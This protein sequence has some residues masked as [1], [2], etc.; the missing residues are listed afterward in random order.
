LLDADTLRVDAP[1]PR[2][3]AALAR[4]LASGQPLSL[5]EVL[6]A[7][8][9]RFLGAHRASD[10]GPSR[11]YVYSWGLA[12]YLTFERSILGTPSFD[13]YVAPT[14][15]NDEPIARFEKLVAEPLEKFEAEWRA[16]ML[17]LRP[18]TAAAP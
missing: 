9:E 13:E 18:S 2:A 10:E 3:L 15:A 6:T 5:A 7:P 8:V 1:N 12:Y 16:A 14:R 4:E 11:L 17:K